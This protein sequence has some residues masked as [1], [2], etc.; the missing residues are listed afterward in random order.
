MYPFERF[1]EKA[2]GVLMIA[3]QEAEH[4]GQSYIGTEHLLFGV[5]REETSVGGAALKL[6]GVESGAV[7][8]S[9]ETALETKPEVGIRQIVPTSRVKRVIEH[10]FDEAQQS[11]SS[12]VGTGHLLIG[13]LL[14]PDGIAAQVLRAQGVTL[15]SARKAI[16]SLEAGGL[17]EGLGGHGGGVLKRG[18]IDVPD[19]SQRLISI[20]VLFPPDYTPEQQEG[21]IR[22]IRKA[23]EGG[24]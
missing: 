17:T 8:A 13:L 20:D 22:R 7:L 19:A 21:L 10:A 24:E 1:S 18:H 12:V 2:K 16:G 4:R 14:E 5:V 11:G 3:Q 6:L 9:V 23:V 15:E